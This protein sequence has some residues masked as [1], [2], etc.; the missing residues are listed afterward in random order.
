MSFTA[1][2]LLSTLLVAPADEFVTAFEAGDVERIMRLWSENSP[3]VAADRKRLM[4]LAIDRV[5]LRVTAHAEADGVTI[6]FSNGERYLL[7]LRDGRAWALVPRHGD[8]HPRELFHRGMDHLEAGDFDKALAAFT[9][10]AEIANDAAVQL[11]IGT[12]YDQRGE[13]GSAARYF[14]E[15][16]RLAEASGHARGAGK[17]L[18]QLG[19]LARTGGDYERAVAHW[20]RALEIFR[21][22]GDGS[23]E[24]RMLNNLANVRSSVGEYD[25]ARAYFDAAL[26]IYRE[27]HDVLGTSSVLNNLAIDERLQ[28][29]YP[30]ALALLREALELS[31]SIDD[32][33][34]VAYALGNIGNVLSFQGRYTDALQ[35]YQ[36]SIPLNDRLGNHEAVAATLIGVGELYRTL[37]HSEQAAEHLRQGLAR[38]EKAGSKEMTAAALHNLAQTWLQEGDPKRALADYTKSL[39]IDTEVGN[40]SG[41]LMNLHNMGR[42]LATLGKREEA[43]HS[44]EQAYA[45]AEELKDR[46]TML[47]SLIELAALAR[48]AGD[49]A[50]ELER[51]RRA[52]ALGQEIALP[53]RLWHVHT[54]LG[55]A[56]RRAGRH[57][58]ARAEIDRAVAIVEELRRAVPGEELAQHAFEN[59][60][61]PYHEMVGILVERGDFASAFEYAER[62]KGRVLLDVL[63]HGLPDLAGPLTDAERERE[64]RLAARL[65]QLNGEYRQSLISGTAG[66][67]RAEKLRQARLEYDAFLTTLYARHPQLRMERG[68]IAPIR[69]SEVAALRGSAADVLLEFVVT[70]E[71]TYLFT[72]GRTLRAYTIDVTA[73][74]L[75]REV[76]A[77]RELLASR[78][79]MYVSAARA[80]YKRLLLPAAGELHGAKTIGIVADGPLWELPFQALQPRERQFVLDRHAVFYAPSLTVLREMRKPRAGAGTPQ[81]LALGNPVIP[82]ETRKR[83]RSVYRDVTLGPVP[84]TETEIR[85]IAALYGRSNS[86]VHVGESAR[87]EV[88]KS[89]AGTFDVLHFATHGVL[90]DRNALDS[91]LLFSPPGSASEDGLLEAREIMRLDLHADLAV[92]SACET[93]RGR[94]GAGEGLIGM[95]WALFVAGVPASVV[96]QWKVDS[97]STSELMIEF[98][99]ALRGG[100]LSTAEALQRAALKIRARTAYQHPFYWAPFVAVGRAH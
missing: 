35:S 14:E 25:A 45:L 65:A 97:A 8:G 31:R 68:E 92:L 10:A 50:L 33:E 95:S 38:A 24:A 76:R 59:M 21:A 3:S 12:V 58:E 67:A 62:A 79:V 29:R 52:L 74:N 66:T 20:T 71:K 42:A 16:L 43:R 51:L 87:E 85:G 1:V 4:R 91:R 41:M 17:A 55:Q 98:H 26:K 84:E 18:H 13:P 88:V 80:L 70:A 37:G 83:V 77:F 86:R 78:D 49:P 73:E 28:G 30:A 40:K 48:H 19:V 9:S 2:V 99:R 75:A 32:V 69:A 100:G 27:Q 36:E 6:A 89:S 54:V 46:D 90:D 39:A 93:A 64:S 61:L 44:F 23:Y 53:D 63:R 72:I 60:V 5:E 34:G 82:Q 94:I 81:L 15:S 57:D 47:Q 22:A 7:Q 56:Y 96:S 11:W